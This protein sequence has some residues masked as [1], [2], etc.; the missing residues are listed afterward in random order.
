MY[1]SM[2]LVP[3]WTMLGLWIRWLWNNHASITSIS[4]PLDS[5]LTSLSSM[6]ENSVVSSTTTY[7]HD[8]NKNNIL[9]FWLDSDH[10][11]LLEHEHLF[12]DTVKQ[13]VPYTNEL[14]FKDRNNN[15]MNHTSSQ[16]RA[17]KYHKNKIKNI[18]MKQ[19]C[20]EYIPTDH[21]TKQP[22]QRVAL[23]ALPGVMS[24]MI[25]NHIRIL[26]NEYNK[27]NIIL[28]SPKIQFIHTS[29]IPPYGYGKTHGLTK[30]IR[31]TTKPIYVQIFDTLSTLLHQQQ[32]HDP[33]TS[34]SSSDHMITM[35]DVSAILQLILRYHCRLSHVAA[36]TAIMT[37]SFQDYWSDPSI[38]LYLL[39]QFIYH[40]STESSSLFYDGQQY[41][42][43][44]LDWW[45]HRDNIIHQNLSRS[46]HDI[47]HNIFIA[48]REMMDQRSLQFSL[49]DNRDS[50]KTML[51]DMDQ[52]LR[53]LLLQQ[54]DE[55]L[56]NEVQ[57]S[58]HFTKWPCEAFWSA[59]GNNNNNH[60]NQQQQVSSFVTRL[61]T[62]VSPDCHHD[63]YVTCFVKRDLCEAKGDSICSS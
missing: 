24:D 44:Y 62:L 27:K 35:D 38:V 53:G 28:Q 55:I 57:R 17:L 32:E 30:I 22:I 41:D 16:E 26:I 48:L 49:E 3:L 56:Q 61:A 31:I 18:R 23:I 46:Y 11:P 9:S 1:V 12:H 37:I 13:C 25:A 51:L 5:S 10:I 33:I 6:N 21:T 43:N 42:N 39:H 40:T 58:N 36:H 34:S 29:H 60:T 19:K 47:N 54:L 20:A 8:N 15:S 50:K 4:H 7:E 59:V 2:L 63:P 14:D 52:N 45:N